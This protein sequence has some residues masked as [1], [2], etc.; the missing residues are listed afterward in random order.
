MLRQR[1]HALC[2]RERR[3]SM[4]RHAR[5][6]RPP[7]PAAVVE[8]GLAGVYPVSPRNTAGED[9]STMPKFAC[10]TT[11]T[12]GSRTRS[13]CHERNPVALAALP[14]A[15]GAPNAS[16]SRFRSWGGV[17]PQLGARQGAGLRIPGFSL[18]A[19]AAI[20]RPAQLGHRPRCLHEKA[21]ADRE[22]PRLRSKLRSATIAS[23]ATRPRRSSS[24]RPSRTW[25]ARTR[26]T[27]TSR[28]SSFPGVKSGGVGHWGRI[29]MPASRS[30][31]ED[32]ARLQVRWILT[33]NVSR[34]AEGATP[35]PTDKA[36]E[37]CNACHK[38][39]G[40]LVGPSYREI[41]EKFKDK[42]VNVDGASPRYLAR[43]AGA[44]APRAYAAA[45][46]LAR[47]LGRAWCARRHG[48]RRADRGRHR[49]E[50]RTGRRR[51]SSRR[52]A[53]RRVGHVVRR[54]LVR[55]RARDAALATLY[56][57]LHSAVAKRKGERRLVR[58]AHAPIVRSWLRR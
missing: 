12:H 45:E 51:R 42:P 50:R 52:R 18:G 7:P 41:A 30:L 14:L 20:R 56:S 8:E 6:R 53:P 40:A 46:D 43:D 39:D 15:T 34:L 37:T 31:G 29:P 9:R 47:A 36:M 27:R 1:L 25:A 10:R 4:A 58:E 35:K 38:L 55:P 23:R 22:E 44:P 33:S 16:Q 3:R 48:D 11:A 26:T 19:C 2:H 21:P 24:V 13:R 17:A 5:R 32:D 57:G 49:R 54:F 28:R